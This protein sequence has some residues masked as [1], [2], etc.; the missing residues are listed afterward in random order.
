MKC[1]KE[2]Q[3]GMFC[4]AAI[5]YVEILV[6]LNRSIIHLQ[7]LNIKSLKIIEISINNNLAHANFVTILFSV[8]RSVVVILLVKKAN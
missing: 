6:L 2:M 1:E 4:Y 7:K 5:L 8:K 3:V